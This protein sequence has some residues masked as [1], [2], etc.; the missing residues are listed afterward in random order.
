MNFFHLK[1]KCLE[2]KLFVEISSPWIIHL[3]DYETEVW[4]HSMSDGSNNPWNISE[5]GVTGE[6]EFTEILQLNS[7]IITHTW[8]SLLL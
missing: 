4:N 1:S 8:Y 6:V 3:G 7:V 2:S 5:K